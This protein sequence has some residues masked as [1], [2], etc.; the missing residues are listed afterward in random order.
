M[1][2]LT[3]ADAL[4]LNGPPSTPAG[5]ASAKYQCSSAQ[6]STV[7]CSALARELWSE[8]SQRVLCW[9]SNSAHEGTVNSSMTSWGSSPLRYNRQR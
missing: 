7:H 5:P 3:R 2:R 9:R 8:A 6:P 4:V 1:L